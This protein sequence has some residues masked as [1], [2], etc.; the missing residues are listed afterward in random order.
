MLALIPNFDFLWDKE[1]SRQM[2]KNEKGSLSLG[3]GQSSYWAQTQEIQS[4]VLKSMRFWGTFYL[5]SEF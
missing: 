2:D 1:H 4:E 5:V 3:L